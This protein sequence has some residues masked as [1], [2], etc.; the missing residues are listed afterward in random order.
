MTA[1]AAAP[2]EQFRMIRLRRRRS[3]SRMTSGVGFGR[4]AAAA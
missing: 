1:A 4:A 2:A 3:P